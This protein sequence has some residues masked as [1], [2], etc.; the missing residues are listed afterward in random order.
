MNHLLVFSF[1]SNEKDYNSQI[2]KIFLF[3]FFFSVH[4]T[5]NAL[6]FSDE[7][8]HTIYLD[9]GH[10]NFIYQISQIIY[11]SLISAVIS[12]L[13]KYLSL[14]EKSIIEMKNEE[15]IEELELIVKKLVKS[16]KIKF[17]LFFFVAFLLLGFFL[18]YN[19]CFCG[20]YVNTQ[21]HL[22]KDSVISFTLSLV[23]PFAISILPGIFR[24]TA[25]KAK[26]KDKFKSYWLYHKI[27]RTAE[28]KDRS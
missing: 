11:S 4:F 2:I 5:V 12:I 8:M 23:Y 3:F 13:I 24:I 16:L 1:Y 21:I 7:T 28:E 26:K 14:S 27:K 15:K 19:S 25:L 6:F 20:I 18:F 17:M 9:E 10:F 22:I